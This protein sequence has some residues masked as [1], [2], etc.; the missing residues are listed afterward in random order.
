[1]P[2]LVMQ[3]WSARQLKARG[4]CQP[5][6]KLSH[7]VPVAYH[8]HRLSCLLLSLFLV[9]ITIPSAYHYHCF[10]CLVPLL[11]VRFPFVYRKALRATFNIQSS[12]SKL[13]TDFQLT[14]LYT[15]LCVQRPCTRLYTKLY[16]KLYVQR[17]CTRRSSAYGGSTRSSASGPR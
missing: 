7:F 8:Y 9:P 17:S 11:F 15:K 2:R 16:T 1:M 13:R 10:R 3:L 5:Q 14:R 6:I 4:V 12:H